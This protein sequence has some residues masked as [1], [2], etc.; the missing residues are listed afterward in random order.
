MIYNTAKEVLEQAK[1]SDGDISV[2]NFGPLY[3]YGYYLVESKVSLSKILQ[4]ARMILIDIKLPLD[5]INHLLE[6]VEGVNNE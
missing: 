2:F 1:E 6:L 5:D 3:E 4:G